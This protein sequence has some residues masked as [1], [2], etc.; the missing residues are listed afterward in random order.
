L[1][2]FFVEVVFFFDPAFGGATR[3]F[4]GARLAFVVASG[5]AAGAAWMVAVSE[6]IVVIK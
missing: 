6:S 2:A 5:S 1:G 3:P 4:R